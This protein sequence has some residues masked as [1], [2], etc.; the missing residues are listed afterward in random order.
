MLG[1][2]RHKYYKKVIFILYKYLNINILSMFMITDSQGRVRIPDVWTNENW[3]EGIDNSFILIYRTPAFEVPR[4]FYGDVRVQDSAIAHAKAV[5]TSGLVSRAEGFEWLWE[6]ARK[7][8]T[9]QDYHDPLISVWSPKKRIPNYPG[10]DENGAMLFME[11]FWGFSQGFGIRF[12]GEDVVQKRFSQSVMAANKYS[13]RGL[14]P[15]LDYCT[16]EGA[17]CL[18]ELARLNPAEESVQKL[19]ASLKAKAA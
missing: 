7:E 17:S 19:F 12:E 8:P 6:R 15:F 1:K 2:R 18:T 16:D 11:G 4:E 5:R 9:I 14:P 13:F 3:R 10:A